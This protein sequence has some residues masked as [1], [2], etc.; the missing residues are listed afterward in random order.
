MAAALCVSKLSSGRVID[1]QRTP[2]PLPI[3]YMR[4]FRDKHG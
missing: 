1:F 2:P 3:K 4:S